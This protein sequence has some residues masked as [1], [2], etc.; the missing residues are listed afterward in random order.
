MKDGECKVCGHKGKDF[1]QLATAYKEGERA[2]FANNLQRASNGIAPAR[3][4]EQFFACPVCGVIQ[5]KI[6]SGEKPNG[7]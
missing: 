3:A 4:G 5:I 1:I 2:F 6:E 7:N